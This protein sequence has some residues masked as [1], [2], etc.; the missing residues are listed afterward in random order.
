MTGTHLYPEKSELHMEAIRRTPLHTWHVEHGATMTVFSGW[1]MPLY[2]TSITAEHQTVRNRAGLFDLCHMGRIRVKGKDC[3]KFLQYVTT[4][5]IEALPVGRIHYAFICNPEGGIIDDVTVYK[6]QDHCL[7]V[8]NAV[9]REAVL[10]WFYQQQGKNA[11]QIEDVGF[12][13]SMLS[14]QGPMAQRVFQQVTSAHLNEL[15]YYQF[16]TTQVADA[17]VIVS[18]TGYTG[19]EGFE[20]Y[21]GALYTTLLW[22]ELLEAGASDGLVPVG[23]GARNTLR[24]EACLPLFGSDITNLTTPLQ[25]GLSKFVG[26]DKKA[27]IGKDALVNSST[28]EPAKRLIAFQMLDRSV[29]RKGCDIRHNDSLIGAVTS[30]TFSPTLTKGIGMGYVDNVYS[31]AGSSIAIVI[32]GKDHPAEIVR[33]PFYKRRREA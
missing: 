21:F 5:D 9:N 2:Y 11:V 7:V 33:R 27:F 3:V 15:D 14:I 6:A 31:Q 26:L 12:A 13:L 28:S 29:P 23:L 22:E 1:E 17:K 19:E 4:N 32:K 16:I 18:R 25:A 10:S 24:L 8:T 30:G 20:L